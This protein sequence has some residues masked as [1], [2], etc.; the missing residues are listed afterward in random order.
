M[1]IEKAKEKSQ[2]IMRPYFLIGIV[3]VVIIAFFL[4]NNA[5]TGKA[6][7]TDV[8]KKTADFLNNYFLQ[9]GMDTGAEVMDVKETSG[10][11][12]VSLL[13]QNDTVVVYVTT[14]GKY[15]MPQSAVAEMVITESAVQEQQVEVTKSDKPTAELYIFSY[16]PA[17]ISTLD[18]FAEAG[19]ILN[20]IADVK[21]KFFS[22]MHG[23]HEKQ[24]NIIQECIQKIDKD[25]YWDYASAYFEEVYSSCASSGDV[26]C[27]R[28]KSIA[29]MKKV[30]ID[31]VAI[32]KCVDEEGEALY[33]A[34]Q[35]DAAALALQYSPSV[36]ING[37]YIRNSDRSPEG[38][39]T[40]ICD[41]F[42]TAPE[43][44]STALNSNTA[45]A[46]GNCG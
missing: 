44:C 18:S 41:A 16:C 6:S 10:L 45:S 34:D 9:N 20:D 32:M 43:V 42:N 1:V 4:F 46:S 19:K 30:G 29:L 26:E 2:L 15:I 12:E 35:N 36:V 21:V 38:L 5:L 37:V 23:E 40:L 33:A 8:G 22:D 28:E 13:Y 3:A 25:K 39:K 24:Q 11:Y 7:K 17:G 27:N 14:D 31:D